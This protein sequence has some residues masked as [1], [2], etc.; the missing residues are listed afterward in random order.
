MCML[1]FQDQKVRRSVEAH[2]CGKQ[3]L[4]ERMRGAGLGCLSV[5]CAGKQLQT[6]WPQ[7]DS[8]D[9]TESSQGVERGWGGGRI[10][11]RC[12]LS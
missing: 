10:E 2:V 11:K 5:S 8:Q 4:T 3:A 1:T 9:L 12:P 6:L 7:K